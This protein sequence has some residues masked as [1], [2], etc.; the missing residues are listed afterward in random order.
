MIPVSAMH[1][2][3]QSHACVQVVNPVI[4][5][6]ETGASYAVASLSVLYFDRSPLPLPVADFLTLLVL[7][8]IILCACCKR[9]S[10]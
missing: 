9:C 7:L 5:P 4:L 6:V 2:D 10:A 8:Y 3:V 1:N